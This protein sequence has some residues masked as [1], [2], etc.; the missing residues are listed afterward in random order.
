MTY[1]KVVNEENKHF[2][3]L[4]MSFLE[5]STD[6]T[7]SEMLEMDPQILYHFPRIAARDEKKLKLSSHF[8]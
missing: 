4:C 5:R 3:F 6:W 8:V 7:N 1:D 2:F